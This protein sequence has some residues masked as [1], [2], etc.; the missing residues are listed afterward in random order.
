MESLT[1]YIYNKYFLHYEE[2]YRKDSP[3]ELY[4]HIKCELMTNEK[5]TD[6]YV[7]ET[8]KYIDF[9]ELQSKIYETFY[10]DHCK[11]CDE[12]QDEWCFDYCSQ[13][14][15]DEHRHTYLEE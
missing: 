3:D 7:L 8:L 2:D 15:A 9:Q 10:K 6:V 13:R 12:P 11:N 1:N 14:C 5:Q 4:D